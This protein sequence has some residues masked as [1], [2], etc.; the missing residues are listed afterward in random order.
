MRSRR[1]GASTP[2]E[3]VNAADSTS[4]TSAC[5]CCRALPTAWVWLTQAIACSLSCCSL[6]RVNH[7]TT[8]IATAA[9]AKAGNR[10]RS[11]MSSLKTS[12]IVPRQHG[13]GAPA[14]TSPAAAEP[15]I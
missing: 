4:R 2:L 5:N 10:Q 13:R 12:A 9:S 6:R 15:A 1:P 7:G 14:G 8:M 3:R 11:Q